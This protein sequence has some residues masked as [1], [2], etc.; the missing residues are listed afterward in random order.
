LLQVGQNTVMPRFRPVYG[1]VLVLL[2]V[3]TVIAAEYVWEGHLGRAGYRR[4][5]PDPAG[6]VLVDIASL[7]PRQVD[8]YRFLNSG[9]QEVKFFV[10]RDGEGVLHVAFDA[11]E[12]HHKLGRGFRH[13]G[14][15]LVDN[16][17]ETAVRLAEVN[18]GGGGCRP[19]PLAHRVQGSTLLI[20]ESDILAGWRLFH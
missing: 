14:D 19:V 8:Y 20:A 2:F 3:S 13:D 4:V 9:N 17:C 15:W 10:G 11:S 12:T 5:G 18:N 7:K 1:I 6:R 16:K